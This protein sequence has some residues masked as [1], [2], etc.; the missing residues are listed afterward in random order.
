MVF[1]GRI[2]VL[3]PCMIMNEAR[4]PV[5]LLGESEKNRYHNIPT[6]F[7]FK[8]WI[9]GEAILEH[10]TI[11]S[12]EI[13][14]AFHQKPFGT[15]SRVCEFSGW[16]IGARFNSRCIG[17]THIMVY[18]PIDSHCKFCTQIHLFF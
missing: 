16:G 12:L 13:K 9:V 11:K 14:N 3:T 15:E 17:L 10:R 2:P 4:K 1:W 18:F 8:F 5:S 6:G 7:H